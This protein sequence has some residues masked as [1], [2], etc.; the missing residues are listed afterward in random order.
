VGELTT[1]LAE[2]AQIG[3]VF[4]GLLLLGVGLLTAWFVFVDKA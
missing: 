4:A 2:A 3:A 1:V